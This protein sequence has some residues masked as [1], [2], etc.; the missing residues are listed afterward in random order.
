MNGLSD[1]CGE[2][3]AYC[4]ADM[5]PESDETVTY[6]PKC[7]EECTEMEPQEELVFSEKKIV[8]TANIEKPISEA[9]IETIIVNGFEGGIGYWA[10]LINTG[11]L[12]KG[13]PKGEPNSMW[14]TKLLT[15]GQGILLYDREEPESRFELTL[16]GLLRG[17]ELNFKNRPWDSNIDNGDAVTYDCIIQYALFGEI[18]YG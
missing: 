3:V 16:E 2:E 5:N 8:G 1:C 17:I 9:D 15:I 18:V 10:G 4:K 13:K 12:W 11:G 6:C 14:A 7:E